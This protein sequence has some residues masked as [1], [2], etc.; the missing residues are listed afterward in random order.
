VRRSG[1]IKVETLRQFVFDLLL[2]ILETIREH[3][4]EI[5]FPQREVRVLNSNFSVT[6]QQDK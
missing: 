1:G 3:G 5:P 2:M 6:R 4:F